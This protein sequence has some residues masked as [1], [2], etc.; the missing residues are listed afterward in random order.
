MATTIGPMF[1]CALDVC[2]SIGLRVECEST[3]DACRA[4]TVH[5]QRACSK[6]KCPFSMIGVII[7][8]AVSGTACARVRAKRTSNKPENMD[9]AGP[10][11]LSTGMPNTPDPDLTRDC[12]RAILGPGNSQRVPCAWSMN[13]VPSSVHLGVRSAGFHCSARHHSLASL[14]WLGTNWVWKPNDSVG[15]TWEPCFV[16]IK[17]RRSIW[18]GD[19]FIMVAILRCKN[20]FQYILRT[21][22]DAPKKRLKFKFLNLH[23]SIVLFCLGVQ[24]SKLCGTGIEWF[25]QTPSWL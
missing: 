1:A 6:I 14:N 13:W 25:C 11:Q 23:K 18:P 19:S 20:N 8:V 16:V 10:V 3:T 15:S 12:K 4:P 2:T 9:C 24:T 5:G 21:K 17:K 22:L 7:V